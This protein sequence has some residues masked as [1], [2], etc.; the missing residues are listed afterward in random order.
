MKET[1][2]RLR[3]HS[4][5]T[6]G[7]GEERAEADLPAT[8]TADEGG[9]RLAYVQAEDGART[10]VAFFYRWDTPCVL[11]MVQSGAR[12]CEFL[13]EKGK[14]TQ[15]LYRIAGLGEIEIKILSHTV[16]NDLTAEGGEILLDYEMA[17]GGTWRRLCLTL[18]L[19]PA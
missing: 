18:S 5:A 14:K 8:L 12:E 9:A 15:A 16:A 3:L 13:F 19:T 2:M 1:K 6:D 10:E 7:A 17:V 4:L 11:K